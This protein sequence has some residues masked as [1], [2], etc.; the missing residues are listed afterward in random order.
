MDL[1]PILARNLAHVRETIADACR[2]AGRQE[3]DVRLVAVTKFLP[4][5]A[6]EAIVRLGVRDLAES[7]VQR[8]VQ[9]R[10]RFGGTPAPAL[11][12]PPPA[13]G[14]VWHLVGSLQRN[15]VKAA[16]ACTAIIHSLDSARLAEALDAQAARDGQAVDVLI[17]VNV[18]GEA[19]KHGVER[20]QAAVLAE[21]VMR[22]PR[23]RLC[24]LMT[25]APMVDDPQL[26]RPHFARLREL[27]ERLRSG[28]T[29]GPGC[30]E[31]S[32]G[33]TSDYAAAVREGAT[34]VRVGSA[35]SEGLGLAGN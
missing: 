16:L 19:S 21:V 5:P 14:I 33:M 22:L 3:R 2:A 29:V 24:G 7:R 34:I 6:I 25:M 27:L 9:R 23:L 12:E 17:E 13:T 11:S 35:L 8:L 32:M 26:A 31:L 28:G 1:S 15:K 18:S 4:D 20:D 10:E 30:R